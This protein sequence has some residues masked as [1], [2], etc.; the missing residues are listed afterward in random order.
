MPRTTAHLA[1]LAGPFGLVLAATALVSFAAVGPGCDSGKEH[2]YKPRPAP[3]GKAAKL[4]TVPTLSNKP[5][6]NGDVYTVAGLIHDFRSRIHGEKLLSQESVTVI[7]YIV[8]TNLGEAP[9]CAVH[10]TGKK[11]GADCEKNPPPVPAL[12]ISDEKGAA[13]NIS[14]P[15]MGW[16]GNYA[17][18]YDA[19]QAYKK[20][21]VK[22]LTKNKW[23][24]DVPNPIPNKDAKIKVVGKYGTS[25]TLASQG[26]ESNPVTGIITYK[27]IE[28]VEPPPTP[29]TLPG[30]KL[31]ASPSLPAHLVGGHL[32]PPL[33]RAWM[34]P[35]RPS[36][37]ATA[38]P[39]LQ[40]A[41]TQGPPSLSL[42]LRPQVPRTV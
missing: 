25:F 42:S 28:Y 37:T 34:W 8:K 2:A 41:I 32:P 16:A 38:R 7:G 1:H 35:H 26:V 27:S 31:P 19:I 33:P 21:K 24:T 22:E 12:W 10:K 11:D 18:I 36:A 3:S 29:G 4:P 20:P 39:H 13:E 30:V 15:V 5:K 17:D 40:R 9:P 23:G 6:K 14:I